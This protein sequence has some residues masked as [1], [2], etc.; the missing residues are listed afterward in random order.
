MTLQC[1]FLGTYRILE[2]VSLITAAKPLFSFSFIS[3]V[4]CLY[5]YLLFGVSTRSCF[6]VLMRSRLWI[7]SYCRESCGALE[8]GYAN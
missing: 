3:L 7:S 8:S 6:K 4:I 2:K 1:T 5:L